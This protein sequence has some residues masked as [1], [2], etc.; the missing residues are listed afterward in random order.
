MQNGD[1]DGAKA[2][3][4][5]AYADSLVATKHHDFESAKATVVNALERLGDIAYLNGDYYQAKEYHDEQYHKLRT[6]FYDK[7]DYFTRMGVRDIK[8]EKDWQGMRSQNC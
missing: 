4:L 7:Y 5:I 3:M 1:V 2:P 6:F 8:A